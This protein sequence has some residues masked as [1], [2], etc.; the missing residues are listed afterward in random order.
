MW[1]IGS[2]LVFSFCLLVLGLTQMGVNEAFAA[3]GVTATMAQQKNA[4][5]GDATDSAF[6][7]NLNL[8][9]H[10]TEALSLSETMR[11]NR[12]WEEDRDTESFDPNLRFAVDNDIFLLDL[13]GSASQRRDST[14]ANR[15]NT[16][17]EST[18]ASNWEKRFWPKLRASY[19]ED[20]ARDDEDPS[21]NDTEGSRENASVDWDLELCRTY[22]NIN[23]SRHTDN[24]TQA[25]SRATSQ[26]AKFDTGRAF[27]DDRLDLRFSQQYSVNKSESSTS[28][29][30]GGVALIPQSLSQVLTGKDATPD[31]TSGGELS[32]NTQLHDG[33]TE[34]ASG[35]FTDGID[36]PPV[37]IAVKVDFSQVD[38]LYL[39]TKNN[40][41]AHAGSFTFDLYTSANGTD[42]QKIG[43][44]IGHTYDPV[45]R[46]FVL[47]IGGPRRLWLKLVITNSSL[48][49]VDFTEVEVYSRVVSSGTAVEQARKSTTAISDFNMGY[50]VLPTVFM[51]YSL[52]VE[53][54]DYASGVTHDR[55]S[56]AGNLRW[57]PSTYLRSSLDLSETL[58]QN[59]DLPETLNRTYGLNFS[60]PPI[61]TVDM[62]L[63]LSRTE[64]YEGDL[65]QR[66]SHDVGLYTSAALYPDLDSSLDLTYGR[67]VEEE[68]DE[69]SRHYTSRLTLTARLIPDVI[70]DLSGE[71]QRT[72]A[73][74]T[75][76]DTIDSGLNVNW[77]TSDMLSLLAYGR[78]R[79]LEG[80]LESR[81]LTLSAAVAA[82]E[83][84]QM[85]VGYDFSETTK[86]INR[87]VYFLSWSLSRALTLQGDAYYTDSSV[88]E[89]W[90]IRGQLIARFTTQ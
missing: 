82:T 16:S 15:R 87:Y 74:E 52:S 65:L 4:S 32:G 1:Q 62:N 31:D 49:Q 14:Q 6:N 70:A 55:R 80:R 61:P 72:M 44:S 29:G 81:S 22:Y 26:F 18:W 45:E 46:R 76:I 36:N 77:R 78:Q 42:W 8:S 88:E 56:Q 66:T 43:T 38:L 12:R 19:G 13:F 20:F 11:Y 50:K 64:E 17:W 73:T 9:Q 79:W 67:A 24:A 53:N 2:S 33:D 86:R 25:T 48:T 3:Q 30:A 89:D 51:A 41:A 21:V 5:D 7:Y 83:K 60:S 54:G 90:L 27:W 37:N 57:D 71:Y 68:S 34:T 58:E 59:G 47:S 84:I 28:V 23:R 10:L 40:D 63:G 35:L 75:T 69:A 85:S 39:Y